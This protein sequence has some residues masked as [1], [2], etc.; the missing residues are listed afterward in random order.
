MA[1]FLAT[2]TPTELA[3]RARAALSAYTEARVQEEPASLGRL[4]ARPA[5]ASKA[6][7]PVQ[8]LRYMA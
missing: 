3:Y 8:G 7:L 6:S 4:P 5:S 2:L 1:A